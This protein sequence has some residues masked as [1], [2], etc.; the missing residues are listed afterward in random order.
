MNQ[1]IAIITGA[2]GGIGKEFVS[3]MLQ[4]TLDEVWILARNKE[5]L[6]QIQKT[7]HDKIRIISMDLSNRC[8]LHAFQETLK[9]NNPDVRYLMNCAG[10]GKMG[11]YEDFSIEE[12]EQ[13]M[14][15]NCSAVIV[16][17]QLCIPYM[18]EG[19]HILNLSSQASFQPDPYL[20]LYAATKAFVTSYSRAL[21]R[22]LLTKKIT[23]TAVCPGWVDTE[24]LL[25][26]VNHTK[27]TFPGLVTARR[28]AIQALKDTKKNKDMSVCTAY[29]KRMQ[30]CSKII[31][32]RVIMNQWLKQIKKYL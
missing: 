16:M 13:T 19:S 28:V 2:T 5:K 24:M 12:M 23:V 14:D 27:V 3:L 7:A 32:H 30:F 25:K 10:N 8:E 4:E 26:E 22:E 29:V 11:S 18:K 31:P 20:N 21:N 1:R 6:E 9:E 15:L 17:S